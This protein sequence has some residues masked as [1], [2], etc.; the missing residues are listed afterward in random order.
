MKFAKRKNIEDFVNF[1]LLETYEN[2]KQEDNFYEDYLIDPSKEK[3]K[4]KEKCKKCNEEKC[5]CDKKMNEACRCE[6]ITNIPNLKDAFIDLGSSIDDM[7]HAAEMAP[8]L[9]WSP[10][11]QKE[12]E[13]PEKE[14]V[15]S[16]K[17]TKSKEK[18]KEEA[19]KKPSAKNK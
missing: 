19:P 16:R 18:E 17:K 2:L 13:E 4:E 1:A 9:K 6:I 10:I 14:K 8:V 5:K 15:K 11:D 7:F 3:E 12:E